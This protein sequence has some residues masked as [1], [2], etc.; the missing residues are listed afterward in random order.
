MEIGKQ[1]CILLSFGKSKGL[2]I[3]KET[4]GGKKRRKKIGEN[5]T[6]YST[7]S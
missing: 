7:K 1:A 2:E 3:E 4:K 5:I 6:F